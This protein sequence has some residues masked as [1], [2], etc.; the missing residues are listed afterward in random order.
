[1]R[2][3]EGDAFLISAMMQRPLG[4]LFVV[5]ERAAAGPAIPQHEPAVFAL[6]DF[7]M[8][9]RHVGAERAKIAFTFSADAENGFVDN[10]N[11][12]SERVVDL[13][14]GS[15]RR[16]FRHKRDTPRNG[17]IICGAALSLQANFA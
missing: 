11:A 2:P 13:K 16:C 15:F 17:R 1:M 4:H 5:H 14:A 7:R 10:D 6:N 3:R 12:A 8:L 9:A